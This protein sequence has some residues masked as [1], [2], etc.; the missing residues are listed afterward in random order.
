MA[1][2]SMRKISF[3]GLK[4]DERDII[5]TL[6]KFGAVEIN[7]NIIPDNNDTTYSEVKTVSPEI[8]SIKQ[9]QSRLQAAMKLLEGYDTRKKP[10]FHVLRDISEKDFEEVISRKADY[11]NKI[12]EIERVLAEIS[13]LKAENIGINKTISSLTVWT[14]YAGR[15]S[16]NK[17]K[18]TKTVFCSHSSQEILNDI[19]KEVQDENLPIY[20]NTVR[21]TKDGAF[22]TITYHHSVENITD[23]LIL[24]YQCVRHEF[25]SV[26]TPS[27]SI[28][29]LRDQLDANID[30]ITCLE[31]SFAEYGSLLP[32]LEILYDASTIEIAKVTAHEKMSTT[33]CTFMFEGW[34][35]QKSESEIAACLSQDYIC[36][37]NFRDPEDDEQVPTLQQNNILG[38][39]VESMGNMYSV[40]SYRSLDPSTIGGFFFIF[41]FGLMLSDAGYGVLV[42]L[43]CAILL[44]FVKMQKS[45]KRFMTLFLFAGISTIFWG[46][47]FGSWFGNLAYTLSLGSFTIKPLWFDPIANTDHFMAFSMLLGVIH[48]YVALGFNAANMIRRGKWVDALCDVGFWYIF[49][50]GEILFL[51]PYIPYY[52]E[53]PIANTLPKIGM[54]LLIVGFLLILFTKGRKSK[55]IFVRLFGGVTCVYSLVSMLSDILSY[56]RL[57]AMGL[58]TGVIIN[59]FNEIAAMA[60]GLAGGF[61]WR[62]IFFIIVFVIANIFNLLINMLGSYVNSCRLMYIEFFGKFYEGD[63]KEFEPLI[64]ETEYIN[65]VQNT[66]T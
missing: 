4:K 7:E 34:I 17:T 60:G 22:F 61:G 35:P 36:H 46:A 18:T 30:R 1:V 51:V 56:T 9:E 27:A 45:M 53:L 14:D 54:P 39:T 12:D 64:Q 6:I 42:T 23:S 59:V 66:N 65:I 43:V 5:N 47:L 52:N 58:A 29:Q 62:I 49:Y 50:T 55:N 44:K 24:K 20:V 37:M 26:D 40:L 11:F 10:L 28:Q 57:M 13:T 21:S 33:R 15:L 63:G 25:E 32:D 3:I 16:D 31:E 2:V 8:N 48:M 41:F 38:S 19:I